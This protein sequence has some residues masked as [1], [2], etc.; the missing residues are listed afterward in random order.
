M[1]DRS[2]GVNDLK[3][4]Q[5]R[6]F[7]LKDKKEAQFPLFSKLCEL[8]AGHLCLDGV[9]AKNIW[10]LVGLADAKVKTVLYLD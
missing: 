2:F 10:N 5:R 7:D 4:I 1:I 6:I 3:N 8:R 9:D